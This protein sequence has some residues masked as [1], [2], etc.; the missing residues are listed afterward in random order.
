MFDDRSLCS[1]VIRYK[2]VPIRRMIARRTN[3]E[4]SEYSRK[5][6]MIAR[7]IRTMR[8]K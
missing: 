4:L 2:V 8:M 6:Q 7:V 3:N 1:L 5:N